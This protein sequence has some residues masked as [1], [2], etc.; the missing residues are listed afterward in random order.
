MGFK[1]MFGP[2]SAL[3]EGLSFKNS[4]DKS[5]K[6]EKKEEKPIAPDN[7]FEKEYARR[8]A[9]ESAKD[10]ALNLFDIYKKSHGMASFT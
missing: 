1:E 5:K 8:V 9:S 6:E 3:F 7:W 4:E 2:F 10:T